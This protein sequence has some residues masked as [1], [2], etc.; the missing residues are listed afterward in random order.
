MPWQM[1]SARAYAPSFFLLLL[2]D[3]FALP[4]ET[5]PIFE[6]ISPPDTVCG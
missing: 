1:E 2:D 3:E 5:H 4:A 6:D